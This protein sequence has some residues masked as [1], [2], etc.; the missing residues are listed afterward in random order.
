[1]TPGVYIS[2]RDLS[3]KRVLVG[4]KGRFVSVGGTGGGGGEPTPEGYYL[5][6]TGN[7]AYFQLLEPTY[8]YTYVPIEIPTITNVI[9]IHNEGLFAN[10]S[11]LALTSDNEL[12]GWGGYTDTK[13]IF[14]DIFTSSAIPVQLSGS[15][16]K[17]AV[18]DAY[19]FAIKTDGTLWKWGGYPIDVPEDYIATPVQV[20]TDDDWV[21]IS[22]YSWYNDFLGYN[23]ASGVTVIGIRSTGSNTLWGFGYNNNGQLGLNNIDVQSELVQLITDETTLPVDNGESRARDGDFSTIPGSE[24]YAPA[25]FTSTRFVFDTGSVVTSSITNTLLGSGSLTEDSNPLHPTSESGSFDARTGGYW[26]VSLPFPVSY[27]GVSYSTIYI[28]ASSGIYFGYPYTTGE[29]IQISMKSYNYAYRIYY[30]Q[31]GDTF[32]IRYEANSSEYEEG[33]AKIWEVVFFQNTPNQIDVHI[34]ENGDYIPSQLLNSA[35]ISGW[36][37]VYTEE[38][39]SVILNNDGTLWSAG[40][41]QY[42]L[43]Q[44]E[45][46]D[47]SLVFGQIGSDTDWDKLAGQR[48]AIKTDG[49]FWQW[50]VD[51]VIA[52]SGSWASG[53]L[54]TANDQFTYGIKS[55]GTLWV[56]NGGAYEQPSG[57][58]NYFSVDTPTQIGTKT[59]WTYIGSYNT[60]EEYMQYAVDSTGTLYGWG[61]SQTEYYDGEQFYLDL[62]GFE[63]PSDG[64]ASRATFEKVNN[65]LWISAYTYPDTPVSFLIKN[66]RTLWA[67]GD[68]S[69]GALGVGDRVI[70]SL[71]QVGSDTWKE[72]TGGYESAAGITLDGKLYTWGS[73]LSGQLG[74][75][76]SLEQIVTSPVW[77]A[78]DSTWKSVS[79][80]NNVC[81]AVNTDG[82]LWG[83]G[84]GYNGQLGQGEDETFALEPVQIG[85]DDD[86]DFAYAS[87]FVGSFAVKTDGSLY[88][89]GYNDD[90]I[91][92][93]GDV[94][95]IY[96]TPTLVD[97]GPWKSIVSDGRTVFALKTDGTLWGWGENGDDRIPGT[98][99][100]D[101]GTSLAYA[102]Y[103]AIPGSNFIAVPFTSTRLVFDTGS[104]VTSSIANT[105]LG[106]GSLTEY[107]TPDDGSNDDGYWGP[108]TLPFSAS[109]N[110]VSYST[111]NVSTNGE[112]WFGDVPDAE[113]LEISRFDTYAYRIYHGQEGDTFRIRWEGN[114][115][116]TQVGTAKVWEV[117]FY[118][119]T[120]NQIDVHIAENGNYGLVSIDPQ[121]VPA[122]IGTDT[123]VSISTWQVGNQELRAVKS[124]GTLWVVGQNNEGQLGLGDDDE[125]YQL[126]QV[127][128]DTDWISVFA[129]GD[130]ATIA[131]K[132]S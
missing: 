93:F 96:N 86:W 14:Q 18:D 75:S 94:D 130:R 81:L 8:E 95:T 4:G 25:P 83:W 50:D 74:N 43:G 54:K 1:M 131:L 88:S 103:E 90:N 110:G 39:T 3:R 111:I 59:D 60:S 42:Q 31:E 13:N 10:S 119:N 127:G 129:T 2:E 77:I 123:W 16:S 6:T 47:E 36:K 108:I 68:N 128:S 115:R 70:S 120:P 38:Y 40:N 132:G 61:K 21:D 99:S 33:T 32:R 27:N 23:A 37:E 53:S 122:Q 82:T 24:G 63:F 62:I 29:V 118:E 92:G 101:E 57:L 11:T 80:G 71:R 102:G 125:R 22:C 85:I 56:W 91:L 48:A 106:T 20:G 76:G 73:N 15:W 97:V 114:S 64:I 66:D 79:C 126:T 100:A 55:D 51:P 109:F 98:E 52:A 44:G 78:Q 105:L 124:D 7:N 26:E 87:I 117:V 45:S 112:I 9:Q 104:C 67:W 49:T 46:V 30:G 107:T 17:I 116:Y 5:Y 28:Y 113:Y 121:P 58:G 89:W 19:V 65:D 69:Y 41:N 12:Y 35:P 84:D 72:V 34:A